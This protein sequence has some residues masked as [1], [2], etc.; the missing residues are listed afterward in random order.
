M[1][2]SSIENINLV[3]ENSDLK[4]KFDVLKKQKKTLLKEIEVLKKSKTFVPNNE[5][6]KKN[7]DLELGNMKLKDESSIRV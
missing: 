4:I 2:F 5:L 1:D 3:D 6:K 7:K